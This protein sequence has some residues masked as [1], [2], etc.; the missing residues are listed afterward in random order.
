MQL[1]VSHCLKDPVDRTDDV[2]YYRQRGH[3]LRR[4]IVEGDHFG[5]DF[6]C[7]R[8]QYTCA[9]HFDMSYGQA[10]VEDSLYEL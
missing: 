3:R 9:I 10:E 4:Y 7:L 2:T 6:C 1:F 5:R 8:R